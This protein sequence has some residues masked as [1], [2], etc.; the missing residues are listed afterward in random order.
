MALE[1]GANIYGSVA[2][3]FVNADGF[4]KSIP[5][6]G[7]GNYLTVGK[8]MGVVRAIIGD[9][10]LANNTYMQAHGTGTPQNRVT[11]SHIFN[12]LAKNFGISQ[13]PVTAIKAFLGH[14]LACASGD[15]IIASLGVWH[16]GIIP[17]IKTTS[18]IADDVHQSQLDFLLDHRQINP[19]DM[20][21]T[22]INSKGFGGNN[23]TAAILSPFVTETMLTKRHG[24]SAMRAFK[25]RQET[26]AEATRAYD[27]ACTRGET[28]P[29]YRFGEDVV[30]GNALTMT[31][32]TISIPGQK[33][34]ISL[35]PNNPYKDMV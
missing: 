1:L 35:T 16:D 13:W 19:S 26:V 29:I 11:E 15:Q 18:A 2:D 25:T 3:V 9:N 33:Q 10:A 32:T 5:G 6:P 4:K 8:A 28:R 14:S 17:G 23:A 34:P 21:A 27:E 24:Q 30:E 7:I 22:F 20:Q 31:P 12:A